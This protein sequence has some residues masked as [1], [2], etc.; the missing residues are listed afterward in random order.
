M[1]MVFGG[2]QVMSIGHFGVVRGLF[3]VSCF[4]VL[5]GLAMVLGR[6]IMV[7]RGLF[8]ML[9]DFVTIHCSLP[10]VRSLQIQHRQ[11]Q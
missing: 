8:M 10:L 4:V 5:C 9:V 1:F 2:V 6:M 11:V 3:V 7:V